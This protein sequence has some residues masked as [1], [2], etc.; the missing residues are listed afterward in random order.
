MSASAF[1]PSPS[2]N[3]ARDRQADEP[4][5]GDHDR[6][7]AADLTPG[8]RAVPP[9]EREDP[10]VSPPALPGQT[11]VDT[12]WRLHGQ[13]T[14]WIGRVDTKASFVL[15]LATAGLGGNALLG[16]GHSAS[17]GTRGYIVGASWTSVTLLLASVFFSAWAVAPRLN[18]PDRI[19]PDGRNFI[20]FGHI[21]RLTLEQLLTELAGEDLA[22]AL[23]RQ[24]KTLSDIAWRKHVL[25][26]IALWLAVFGLVT[27]ALLAALA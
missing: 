14:D 24:I 15:A 23:A 8:E 18:R 13:L 17:L 9:P 26:Q 19:R 22:V 11:S 10:A 5:S 7:E 27:T 2:P 20:Y 6:R 25:V 4:T 16:G 12:A 21:R 3:P 1:Q